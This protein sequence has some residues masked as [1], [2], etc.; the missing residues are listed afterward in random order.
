MMGKL[1][2]AQQPILHDG[3]RIEIGEHVDLTDKQAKVLG[4]HVSLAPEKPAK[5]AAETKAA[6]TEAGKAEEKD[7]KE[8][9]K[10]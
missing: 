6:E 9:P 3:E 10:N 5:K 2:I 8:A 4:N 1:Y 7:P